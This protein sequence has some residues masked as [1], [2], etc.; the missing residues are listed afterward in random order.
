MA[1][2]QGDGEVILN[3]ELWHVLTSLPP[4]GT[5]NKDGDYYYIKCH[6]DWQNKWKR[7]DFVRI[8]EKGFAH[9]PWVHDSRELACQ[10]ADKMGMPLVE[11]HPGWFTPTAET[12]AHISVGILS[13]LP[14]GLRLGG[15]VGFTVTAIK[16]FPTKRTLPENLPG[17]VSYG[18]GQRDYATHWIVAEVDVTDVPIATE[19]KPHISLVCY[20]LKGAKITDVDSLHK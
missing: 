1:D 18:E 19:W 14:P 4:C 2:L 16:R 8:C 7:G 20:G 13:S 10:W 12:G 17:Q 15:E 6:S 5:I 3:Q 11:T 9:D